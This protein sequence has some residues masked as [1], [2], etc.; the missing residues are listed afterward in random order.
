MLKIADL[1]AYNLYDDTCIEYI[2]HPA[3]RG[4]RVNDN[5]LWLGKAVLINEHTKWHRDF[6]DIQDGWCA[7]AYFG[8]FTQGDLCLPQIDVRLGAGPGDVILIRSG[9]LIHF[10]DEWVGQ[11]RYVIVYFTHTDA[12]QGL[13]IF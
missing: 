4:A 5:S 12:V 11:G 1:D 7:L 10:V 3:A 9:A 13:G 6:R 2:M 8:D